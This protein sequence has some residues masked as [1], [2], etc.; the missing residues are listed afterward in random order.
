MFKSIVLKIWK[1]KS[2]L[3]APYLSK[4]LTFEFTNGNQKCNRNRKVNISNIDKCAF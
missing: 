3:C 2:V 4:K 1:Y